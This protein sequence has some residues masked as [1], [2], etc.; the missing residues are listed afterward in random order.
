MAEEEQKS[1]LNLSDDELDSFDW[2]K[3]ID[4]KEPGTEEGSEDKDTDKSTEKVNDDGAQEGEDLQTA[5]DSSGEEDTSSTDLDKDLEDA[6]K[7]EQET[8][9][10]EV[11]ESKESSTKKVEDSKEVFSADNT[12]KASKSDKKDKPVVKD[13]ADKEKEADKEPTEV[14]YQAELSKVLAPFKANGKMMQVENIEDA[15]TLMQMGAN[16]N[17]KMAGLKPNLKL[18]KMLENNNLLDENK[19]SYL[20]DLSKKNPEA[21]KTL[22]K[23][24]KLDGVEVDPDMKVNYQPKTY[25][26]NDKEV[27]L[28]GILDEIRDTESY[29]T[30]IDIISNKWDESSQKAL[31][32]NPADIAAINEHVGSGIYEQ[33]ASV[34]AREKMLGRLKGMT[35]LEAYKTVGDALNAAGKFNTDT[36]QNSQTQGNMSKTTKVVDPKLKDKKRAASSTKS[37]VKTKGKA[38]FNPLALSDT[39][40]DKIGD[41]KFL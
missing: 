37:S 16:Y 39:E 41:A 8:K 21:I 2:D 36:Q 26:V 31:F 14:D 17:K 13:N 18:V 23:D 32:N 4:T 28:D 25:T 22:L 3:F 12:D 10:K 30:T 27:E 34:M 6:E 38:E 9:T 29:S 35:D 7:Q 40:F 20:I 33:V 15:R 5:D 11:V 19:L 1:P 24:S